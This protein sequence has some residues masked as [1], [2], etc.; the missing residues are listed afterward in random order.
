MARV[1]PKVGIPIVILAGILTWWLLRTDSEPDLVDSTVD[2]IALADVTVPELLSARARA[3]ERIFRENC[4][5]CHGTNAAGKDG[6][7]P[8]LVHIFYEP[9][10]HGDEAI[11]RAVAIGVESH[12][13]SF[14]DMA[15][16][17][18]LTRS[19]V[20]LVIAYIRE[21]QR[22]NGIR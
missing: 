4:V 22:A 8:P 21:L 5:I 3:G 9:S 13:W 20:A 15:P 12:H 6:I 7:G 11:Q 2:T 18:G 10:H 19:D 17:E 14:G 16:V 1:G